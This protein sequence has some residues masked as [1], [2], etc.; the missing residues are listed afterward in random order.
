MNLDS[1]QMIKYF[2]FRKEPHCGSRC[3]TLGR[4]VVVPDIRYPPHPEKTSRQSSQC[5]H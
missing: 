5:E 3:L 4:V 1:A 2:A